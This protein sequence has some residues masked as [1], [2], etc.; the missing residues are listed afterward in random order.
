M[1]FPLRC[2]RQPNGYSKNYLAAFTTLGAGVIFSGYGKTLVTDGK[3][4]SVPSPDFTTPHYELHYQAPLSCRSTMKMPTTT[5]IRKSSKG[6]RLSFPYLL[7]Q[8]R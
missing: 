2:I 5:L 7:L 4:P 1:P 3:R 6:K 8:I